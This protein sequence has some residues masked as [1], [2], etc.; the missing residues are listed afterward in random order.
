M[1]KGYYSTSYKMHQLAKDI[2]NAVWRLGLPPLN[3]SHNGNYSLRIHNMY[4]TFLTLK[5]DQND[6]YKV[7]IFLGETS[8][9]P[10]VKYD[11]FD[12]TYAVDRILQYVTCYLE[13]LAMRPVMSSTAY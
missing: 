3:V 5:R 1:T 6:P 11:L 2:Q 9:S 8:N 7:G 12:C 10:S 13:Y 4:N